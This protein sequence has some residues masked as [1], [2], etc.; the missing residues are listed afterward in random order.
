MLNWHVVVPASRQDILAADEIYARG[1]EIHLP[2]TYWRETVSSRVILRWDLRLAGYLYVQFDRDDDQQH[3]MVAAQRGV[4]HVLRG[5]NNRPGIVPA[6][7]IR[8]DKAREFAEQ[9]DAKRAKPK[10]AADSMRLGKPYLIRGHGPFAGRSGSLFSLNRG[11][12]RI[13]CD[14]T[15]VAVS[16]ADIA[17]CE[18]R[19][20]AA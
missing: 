13:D 5:P 19:R 9:A 11:I 15:I 6:A 10:K 4:H 3:A 1:F 12:A 17:P 8:D 16:E 14:G 20:G 7:V 2:K 18:A